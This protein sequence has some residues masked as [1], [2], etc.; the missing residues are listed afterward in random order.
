LKTPKKDSILAFFMLNFRFIFDYSKRAPY[1][2]D[3]AAGLWLKVDASRGRN[4]PRKQAKPCEHG[5]V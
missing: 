3:M 1:N 2:P 5:A 4:D